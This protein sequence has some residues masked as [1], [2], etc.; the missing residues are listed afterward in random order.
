MRTSAHTATTGVGGVSVGEPVRQECA[1]IYQCRLDRI[2]LPRVPP[3]TCAAAALR[4]GDDPA[5]SLGIC[6]RTERFESRREAYTRAVGATRR[7]VARV[8]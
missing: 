8:R 3:V 4:V 2:E 1:G 5:G 6:A 7:R